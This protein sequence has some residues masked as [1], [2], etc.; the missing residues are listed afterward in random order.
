M[1][2]CSNIF[3]CKLIVKMLFMEDRDSN[4]HPLCSVE[5]NL[6]ELLLGFSFCELAFEGFDA[7]TYY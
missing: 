4:Q 2:S 6:K 3:N 5:E 7:T 1:I